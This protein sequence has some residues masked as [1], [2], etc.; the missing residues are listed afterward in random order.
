MF[1]IGEKWEAVADIE[2]EFTYGGGKWIFAAPDR[3]VYATGVFYEKQPSGRRKFEIIGL[4]EKYELKDAMKIVEPMI[5]KWRDL[6][7]D[8]PKKAVML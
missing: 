7:G 2:L 4:L 3:T 8:L 1:G 5:Y 6:K